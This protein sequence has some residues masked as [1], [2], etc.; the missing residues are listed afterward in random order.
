[1]GTYGITISNILGYVGVLLVFFVM[2]KLYFDLYDQFL[3]GILFIGL[4]L[5]IN[6]IQF[7]KRKRK[8]FY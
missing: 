3:S 7:L 8:K 2:T 1:M 5:L 4:M 6:N